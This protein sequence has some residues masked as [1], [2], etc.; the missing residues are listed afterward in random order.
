M[1][2][3]WQDVSLITQM[4]IKRGFCRQCC[5]VS[6]ILHSRSMAM[7]ATAPRSSQRLWPTQDESDENVQHGWGR[8]YQSLILRGVAVRDW[9]LPEKSRFSLVGLIKLSRIGQKIPEGHAYSR[10]NLGILF[11]RWKG[12]Q[13]SQ[14]QELAFSMAVLSTYSNGQG[15]RVF[16]S[17]ARTE[18]LEAGEGAAHKSPFPLSHGAPLRTSVWGPRIWHT[19]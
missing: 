5:A 1:Q 13:D 6:T 19:L 2:N 16:R 18:S 12:N 14:G 4:R 8:G 7:A 15:K 3:L 9:W 17:V 10:G 11:V